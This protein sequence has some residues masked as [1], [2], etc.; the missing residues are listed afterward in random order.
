MSSG[1]VMVIAGVW[2]ILQVTKGGL[3]TRLGL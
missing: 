3:L 1:V 2:L